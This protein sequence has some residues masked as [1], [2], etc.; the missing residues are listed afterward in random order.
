MLDIVKE[1]DGCYKL[2]TDNVTCYINPD[3]I[4]YT[5]KQNG[6]TVVDNGGTRIKIHSDVHPE[7]VTVTIKCKGIMKIIYNTY[8]QFEYYMDFMEKVEKISIEQKGY[9]QKWN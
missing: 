4:R 1:S 5:D 7:R 9:K 3:M 8:I 6:F 2:Y